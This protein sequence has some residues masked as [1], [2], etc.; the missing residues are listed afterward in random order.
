MEMDRAAEGREIMT[1]ADTRGLRRLLAT[2]MLAGLFAVAACDSST[3]EPDGADPDPDPGVTTFSV[4]LTDNPGEVADVWVAITDVNLVGQG[5][6]VPLLEEPTELINLME[7]RNTSM[8]LIDEE[9]VEPG[10]YSQLRFVIDAAVLETVGGQ[11]YTYGWGEHPGGLESTGE[12]HCPSCGQSGLKVNFAGGLVIEEGPNAALVD[13]DVA[14]S[15]GRQ[16]GQSG[17]WVMR[18]LIQ[19]VMVDPDVPEPEGG[20]IEGEVQLATV[21][22]TPIQIPACAGE[23]RGLEDFTPMATSTE[24]VDGEGDPFVFAGST[25]AA[26]LFEIAVLHE[27]E[28]ELGYQGVMVYE[29]AELH[30]E[31]EVSPTEV[32]V[33]AGGTASGV[34]YTIT[35]ATCVIPD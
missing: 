11:V 15:F 6:P 13:F 5:Q 32:D 7:L 31:A 17:R 24:L 12:L 30:W 9:E 27:G 21:E 8:L 1:R 18:P 3:T 19:G 14:Q 28:Y 4:Y 25:T 33:L 22:G 10:T 29:D 34:V 20:L 35:G 23:E 16:A 2:T 26:G